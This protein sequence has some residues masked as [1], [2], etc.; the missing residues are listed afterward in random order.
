[1]MFAHLRFRLL[2]SDILEHIGLGDAAVGSSW[3]H[4]VDVNL[5]VLDELPDIGRNL[6]V[7]QRINDMFG[8]RLWM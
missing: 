3:N 7:C 6:E 5:L 4:L 8:L 2:I 1:M